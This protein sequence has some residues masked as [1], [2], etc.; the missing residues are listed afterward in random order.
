M[1]N[2]YNAHKSKEIYYVTREI[3]GE[4]YNIGKIDIDYYPK[5]T[6]YTVFINK[7][8]DVAFF[9]SPEPTTLDDAITAITN[10]ADNCCENCLIKDYALIKLNAKKHCRKCKIKN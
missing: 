6:F 3:N 8:R 4:L 9:P 10:E 1:I 5:R 2:Y 7:G